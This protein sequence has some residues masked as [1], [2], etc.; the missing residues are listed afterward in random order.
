MDIII[1]LKD[2]SE[3]LLNSS[4]F[5]LFNI[6]YFSYLLNS[7]MKKSDLRKKKRFLW[8][9]FKLFNFKQCKM[10]FE[11]FAFFTSVLI[12]IPTRLKNILKNM[13]K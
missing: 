3:N 1:K 9:N 5:K 2:S 12:S 4:K 10:F 6:L 11:L 8:Q 7:F 13:C